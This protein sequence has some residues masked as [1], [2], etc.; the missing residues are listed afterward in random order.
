MHNSTIDYAIIGKRIKD[1]RKQLHITQEKMAADVHLSSFY[2]SRIERGSASSTL[3]TLSILANYLDLDI[4]FL[5]S[6]TSTLEK[7]YYLKQL[8]EICAKATNKQLDLITKI[9]KTIIDE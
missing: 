4:G 5:I 6:G 3:D 2:L 7:N 8:D 1:K 9:A